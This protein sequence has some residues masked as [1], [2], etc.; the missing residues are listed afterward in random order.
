MHAIKP[1]FAPCALCSI[2]PVPEPESAMG[3]VFNT[4]NPNGE[5]P[6]R[7]LADCAVFVEDAETG[8]L[9]ICAICRR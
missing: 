9:L 7:A 4:E 6:M 3:D 8:N 1:T 5:L 2:A